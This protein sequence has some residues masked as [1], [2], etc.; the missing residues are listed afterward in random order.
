MSGEYSTREAIEHVE[1][2]HHE[3]AGSGSAMLRWVPLSAAILAICAGLSSLYGGIL[4]EKVLALKN[5]AVLH[6]VTASDTWNQYQAESLKAHL[7]EISAQTGPGANAAAMRSEAAKYRN[8]QPGLST[9]A[10]GEEK[11]RD[12]ALSESTLLEVRKGNFEMGLSFFEVAIVLTSIAAM[13]KRPALMIG[14]GVLG[15][16]GLLFALRG[17]I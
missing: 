8:E 16:V 9:A 15:V 14:A 5:E 11:A 1:H 7:Y 13:V 6:E 4:G 2:A 17:F 3:L 10:R 12:E